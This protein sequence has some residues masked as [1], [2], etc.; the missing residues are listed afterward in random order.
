MSPSYFS[1]NYS[2]LFVTKKGCGGVGVCLISGA[3][4]QKKEGLIVGHPNQHWVGRVWAVHPCPQPLLLFQH[5]PLHNQL[6]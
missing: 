2:R 3:C 6:C 1:R 4:V 5:W